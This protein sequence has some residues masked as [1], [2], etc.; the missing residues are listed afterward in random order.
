MKTKLKKQK[1]DIT[2]IDP[3]T[4]QARCTFNGCIEKFTETGFEVIKNEKSGNEYV[5]A[6]HFCN[7]CG[8]RVKAQGDSSRAF[9]MWVK[10]MRERDTSTLSDEAKH[11]LL[12]HGHV[13]D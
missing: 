11:M 8:Q 13:A 2:F 5:S 10:L 7:E 3:K 1:N 12:F 9:K 4:M 6:F